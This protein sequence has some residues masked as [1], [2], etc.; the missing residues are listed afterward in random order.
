MQ[1]HIDEISRH[2]ASGAYAVLIMGRAGGRMTARMEV[3]KTVTPIFRPSRVPELNPVESPWGSQ[4]SMSQALASPKPLS[5]VRFVGYM[6]RHD[7]ERGPS[8]LRDPNYR[9]GLP[10]G[11]MP[12]DGPGQSSRA[13]RIF[14]PI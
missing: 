14:S 3:Q 9:P 7:T 1:E 4:P 12:P 6:V 10:G 8:P 5:S 11:L 2:V 13:M